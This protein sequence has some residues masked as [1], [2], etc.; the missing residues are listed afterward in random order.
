VVRTVASALL[1]TVLLVSPA[2]ATALL[3]RSAVTRW[4][5]ERAG[6]VY[7]LPADY[8]AAAVRAIAAA[9]VLAAAVALVVRLPDGSNGTY[10]QV[11]LNSGVAA[12]AA[13]NPAPP[14]G[15][16]AVSPPVSAP[17]SEEP[18]RT[19]GN[20]AGGTLQ[21][22]ADGTRVWL[23]PQ[24]GSPDAASRAFPLVVAYLPPG[25]PDADD[26]YPAFQPHRVGYTDPF[27]LVL[28]PRCPADP[29]SVL[30]AVGRRY[31]TMPESVAH[32]VLGVGDLAPCAVRDGLAHPDRYR[33]AVGVSGTYDDLFA[34]D[35]FASGAPAG[36]RPHV[37]LASATGEDT[38]RASATRLREELRRKGTRVRI[39]ERVNAGARLGGGA[40]RRVIALAAGYL[41]QQLH[42]TAG[43]AAPQR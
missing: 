11:R 7:E 41:A 39:L 1:C 42:G 4:S 36:R 16:S 14:S 28:P 32:A 9:L 24:Y 6:K 22:L 10:A 43:S 21:E 37:L 5:T 12:P 31:R 15:D 27:L 23:P 19:I 17:P 40:H 26:L 25:T 29:S 35:L 30:D 13:P 2:A 3:A 34:S 38:Q 33:A 20:P 8:R 18:P